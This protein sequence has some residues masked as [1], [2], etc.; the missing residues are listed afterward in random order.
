LHNYRK[1]E[2]VKEHTTIAVDLSKSVFEVAISR[3]PGRVC[4]RRRLLR[5]Q[6]TRFFAQRPPATVLL[7][8]CG[9]SHHWARQIESLG[10]RVLLLPPHHTRRYV[11]RDK[12]DRPTRPRFWKPIATSKS[13]PCLSRLS[14]SRVSPRST[15]CA[16]AGWPRA[17]RG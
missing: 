12:T 1:E 15:G 6:M 9:S 14:N 10:H 11:L 7:E 4:E 16:L 17:P 3:D 13:R 2:S 8:A 5:S